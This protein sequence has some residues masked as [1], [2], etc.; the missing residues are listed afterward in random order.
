MTLLDRDDCLLAVVD[1][2]RGFYSGRPDVLPA[3]FDPFIGQVAR[4]VGVAAAL[5]VPVVVTE[6]DPAHNGPTAPEVLA[7]LAPGNSVLPKPVFN[8]AAVD[9]IRAAVTDTNRRTAVLAG[10]ETDVCVA[11]SAF[12][13]MEENYRV[14]AIVD[15]L[16]SPGPGHAE[17]LDRLRSAG[18]EL[19]SAKAVYYD[20]M[21]TLEAARAFRAKFPE[22]APP[23]PHQTSSSLTE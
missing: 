3:E 15:A 12:G 22:L 6:E 14:V 4:M 19:L 2:Q 20:W 10:M 9:T 5:D 18:V 11:Q 8:L 21:R 17:G 7:Q 1:V 13:L 16:F 23:A